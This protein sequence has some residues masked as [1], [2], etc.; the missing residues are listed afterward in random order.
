[1]NA[2]V[3]RLIDYP[4]GNAMVEELQALLEPLMRWRFTVSR[5]HSRHRSARGRGNSSRGSGVS[6]MSGTD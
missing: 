2:N 4:K 1:M 5:V 3:S 6:Q